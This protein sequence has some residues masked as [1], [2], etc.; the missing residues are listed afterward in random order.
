[1]FYRYIAMSIQYEEGIVVKTL[2]KIFNFT[3]GNFNS[4]EMDNNGI[5]PF[6]SCKSNDPF[7]FHS[8]HSFDYPEYLL[9]VCAGISEKLGKCY[10]VNGKTACHKDIYSLIPKTEEFN[11]KYIN[12]YL[13]L[14]RIKTNKKQIL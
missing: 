7:G 13:N 6:Y 5:I 11:I 12:Y 3:K 8:T 1:M 4:N 14:N 9:L 10:Y 2:D